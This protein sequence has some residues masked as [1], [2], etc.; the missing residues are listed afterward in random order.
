[1]NG[2]IIMFSKIKKT[3]ILV[4]AS[5]LLTT[6][7][8][9]TVIKA[10]SIDNSAAETATTNDS[11][12]MA[13]TQSSY[14]DIDVAAVKANMLTELNRLR[15]QNNL[16]PL[17]SVNVL[18]NY[19]QSRTDSFTNTGVDNHSNWNTSDM[20]PYNLTA[21]ENISQMPYSMIGTTDPLTIAQKVTNE[22]Y[23]EE[24]DRTPDYGHR[25]NILN[26]YVTY[27]GIG[28]TVADNGMIYFSQEIGND[29]ASRDK[30]DP[31]TIANYDATRQNDYAN[32][33]KYDIADSKR[34]SAD[35]TTRDDY[36]IADIRGGVSTKN[37]DTPL[38]D[39]YGNKRDDLDLSPN[40]DWL[41]DII[42]TINGK[43]YYHVSNNGF[44]SSKDVLPWAKFL[45]GSS[46]TTT[47]EANIYDN[48]GN[49][50]GRKVAAGSKMAI[51]RRAINPLTKIKMYHIGVNAWVQENQVKLN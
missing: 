14:E 33:S 28:V 11:S 35:Y 34:T 26:P 12:L 22:F 44:V 41:S 6:T 38:Y 16:Q 47:T 50:T 21:E 32:P 46:I 18:N 51:D 7:L 40:S 9:G 10:E 27:V 4:I 37:Y 25:K 23:S 19:A 39:R 45:Y 17:I 8:G 24:Y 3:T 20:Y 2:G 42:A 36:Q 30:F 49:F 48:N 29:E 15:S 31:S 13:T 43:T 5:T 1:M